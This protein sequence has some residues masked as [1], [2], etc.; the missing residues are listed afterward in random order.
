MARM[1]NKNQ[2]RDQLRLIREYLHG[3]MN[4]AEEQSFFDEI[5]ADKSLQRL[6]AAEVALYKNYEFEQRCN[7]HFEEE[8]KNIDSGSLSFCV[9]RDIITETDN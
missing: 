2:K 3:L 5:K 6:A 9:N 8:L 4:D 7:E 1:R